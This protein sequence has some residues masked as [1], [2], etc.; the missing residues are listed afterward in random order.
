[1]QRTLAIIKPDVVAQG[2][3]GSII[4]IIEENSFNIVAMKM[5]HLTLEQTMEF[6]AV[7]KGKD[8]F[9]SNAK[10]M[11][12]GPCIMMVLEGKNA[13]KE[14][15]ELMGPT[16]YTQAREGTIRSEFATSI[17]RNA[18]HGSDS[19]ESADMEITFFNNV[20]NSNALTNYEGVFCFFCGNPMS[21]PHDETCPRSIFK[22]AA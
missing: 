13:I 18:V 7:H 22:K 12:S 4:N 19:V 5:V 16:D 8:F 3:I 11:S 20:T 2:Y 1:M 17:Q 10:F 9:V 14:W 6:Y 15:R 21:E